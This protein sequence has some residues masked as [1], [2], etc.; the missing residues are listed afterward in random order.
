MKIQYKDKTYKV[1]KAHGGFNRYQ[2]Y[3]LLPNGERADKSSWG[4][5]YGGGETAE[6]AFESFLN[7]WGIK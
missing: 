3:E 2:I 5:R 1:I 7:M 6:K 4:T